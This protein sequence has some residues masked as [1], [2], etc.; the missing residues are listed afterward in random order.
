MKITIKFLR[1]PKWEG[2]LV[3]DEKHAR[4]LFTYSML[5]CVP[6]EPWT[7]MGPDPNGVQAAANRYLELTL[8]HG[9]RG[10]I[11]ADSFEKFQS[12]FLIR[13]KGVILDWA[14]LYGE[15]LVPTNFIEEIWTADHIQALAGHLRKPARKRA[16]LAFLRRTLL[17]CWEPLK[18][19]DMDRREIAN[20]IFFRT[21]KD[22]SPKLVWETAAE[23]GLKTRRASG[24]KQRT[25]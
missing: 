1:V 8:R 19:H 12:E 25:P 6:A 5:P 9:Q 15:V 13:A 20:T 11:S 21:L 18:L 16:S 4:K 2:S 17:E 23:L 3:S 7:P 24:P 14:A 22:Y 10:Q